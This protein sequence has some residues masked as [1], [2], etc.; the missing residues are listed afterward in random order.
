M[1]FA[2]HTGILT[3]ALFFIEAYNFLDNLNYTS[4][5]FAENEETNILNR[6]LRNTVTRSWTTVWRAF[7]L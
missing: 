1:N 4:V 7:F 3:I 2:R 6:A 5:A